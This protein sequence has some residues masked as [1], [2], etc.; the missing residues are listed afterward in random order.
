M[1]PSLDPCVGRTTPSSQQAPRTAQR[2]NNHL[3]TL[4]KACCGLPGAAWPGPVTSANLHLG[5]CTETR[6]DKNPATPAWHAGSTCRSD[7]TSDPAPS[8]VCEKAAPLPPTLG[9]RMELLARGLGLPA[10]A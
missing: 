3:G 5:A 1:D 10:S 6:W 2:R 4:Q 7:S 8:P 9:N